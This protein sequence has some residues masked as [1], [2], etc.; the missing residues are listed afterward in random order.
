MFNR[1][2]VAFDNSAHAQR[3][4]EMGLQ[5][6]KIHNSRIH[7]VTV[8]QLPD[9]AG[10]VD[11]VDEKIQEGKKFY[12]EAIAAAVAEAE[13]LGLRM[14]AK[15]LYGHIGQTLV[16]YAGD[17]NLDLIITGSRGRSEVEKLLL[18]SVSNYLSRHARCPVLIVRQ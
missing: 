12:L 13:K 2:M 8:V 17:N 15:V 7:L 10:T 3:A 11:E 16:R 5:L 9:Y 6:A 14:T 18:G 1:I 4:L